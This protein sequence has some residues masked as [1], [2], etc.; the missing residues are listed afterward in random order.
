MRG[1]HETRTAPLAAR[2][3]STRQAILLAAARAFADRGYHRTTLHHVAAEV[4]IQKASIFHHFASKEALYRAVLAEGHGQGEAIVRCAVA[5]D[6]SW[7]T[8]LRALLAA[9]VDLVAAHP[10]QTKILLRQSLGDAPEGYSGRPD[11]NRLLTLVAH[12]LAEGQRAGAFAAVD[13]PSLVL[14][15]MG[16]VVFFFTSAP[17]VAPGWMAPSTTIEDAE[18]VRRR[19]AAIVERVLARGVPT[20]PELPQPVRS[21]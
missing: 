8:R 7:W 2:R 21:P 1:A 18:A 6:G 13:G 11:A 17:V 3:A 10:E 5:G 9:Y 15:V 14:G 19:V 16:M 20:E 4:G 12:F